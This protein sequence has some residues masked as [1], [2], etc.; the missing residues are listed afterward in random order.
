MK[1]IEL[2]E[3]FELEINKLDDNLTKPTTS[4]IEYWL[5]AGL[6]K[7]IKTR[8]SGVNYKRIGF[9]QDQKRTDDLRTLI[10]NQTYQFTVYPEEYVIALP[11][12]YMLA[13]G[14]TVI[15]SS[16]VTSWPKNSLGQPLTKHVDVLEA[17]V[18][19][20]DSQKENSLSEYR[21]HANR[22]RPLRLF[23]GNEVHLFT[24]GNY[25][26]KN[27]TLTYLKNPQ[28]ISLT[29]APFSEYTDMPVATHQ[30]IVKLAAQL[31]LENKANPRYNSYVNETNTME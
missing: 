16:T 8:Y 17:T 26:I 22:A 13:L 3:S 27:Y 30:E 19:N 5:M 1:F 28:R 20:I 24:D 2:Q 25:F 11:S 9:E 15:I 14:E 6:D 21:L 10:S 23:S 29:T 18:E 4:E 12:N 31:Y 7:F